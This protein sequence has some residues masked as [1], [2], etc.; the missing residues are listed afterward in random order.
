MLRRKVSWGAKC[1]SAFGFGTFDF[2]LPGLFWVEIECMLHVAL[3]KRPKNEFKPVHLSRQQALRAN[4]PNVYTVPISEWGMQETKKDLSSPANF[5]TE[6][7]FGF[8]SNRP[9]IDM[10]E[11]NKSK[12]SH[13]LS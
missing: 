6:A 4:C 8:S 2:F 7:I 9:P 10:P 11:K 5:V 3:P 1:G 12:S 13:V